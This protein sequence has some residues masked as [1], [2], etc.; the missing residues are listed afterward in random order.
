MTRR[1]QLS[2]IVHDASAAWQRQ[3]PA[4][5]SEIEQLIRTSPVQLPE[6]YLDFLRLSNGGS[7]PLEISPLWFYIWGAREVVQNNMAYEREIFYPDLY[8][9]GACDGNLFGFNLLSRFPW[10]LIAIDFLDSK[11]ECV[12]DLGTDFMQFA[13]SLGDR[14][15]R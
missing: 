3:P 8:L 15:P 14:N 13:R 11:R 9:F 7:G 10:R 4:E 6:D 2:R 1:E 5:E 12:D